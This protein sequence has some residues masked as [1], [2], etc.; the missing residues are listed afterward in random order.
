MQ[1]VAVRGWYSPDGTNLD[2]SACIVVQTTS[3]IVSP[4]D[5][6]NVSIHVLGSAKRR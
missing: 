1:N 3:L 4:G 6:F 5:T 2:S